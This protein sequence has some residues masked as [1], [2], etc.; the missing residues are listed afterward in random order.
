MTDIVDSTELVQQLGEP[1]VEVL[2]RQRELLCDVFTDHGGRVVDD[3]G[4]ANF[5]V[6]ERPA[7]AINAAMAAQRAVGAEPWPQ[8]CD[9]R[10][11]IGIHTGEAYAV[12]NRFVGTR[13]PR[14]GARVPG[15]A[16]GQV[17]VSEGAAQAGG[18]EREVDAG[19]MTSTASAAASLRGRV[20]S[21][22]QATRRRW[23]PVDLAPL[24]LMLVAMFATLPGSHHRNLF[25]IVVRHA[26]LASAYVILIWS[27]ARKREL[28][29]LIFYKAT[30]VAF[31][32]ALSVLL[33]GSLLKDLGAGTMSLELIA[34][35]SVV[36]W[37]V[38]SF[39]FLKRAS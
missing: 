36:I 26:G 30:T 5:A 13:R 23:K 21:T 33:L 35:I 11:R 18:A 28:D 12:G 29:R 27:A 3:T 37:L 20:M 2:G 34:E 17:L 8:G 16:G 7:D 22:P 24:G 19:R 9:L 32:V 15:R 39:E 14:G 10:I 6:F 31:C 25:L 4:D 1:Y 38:A